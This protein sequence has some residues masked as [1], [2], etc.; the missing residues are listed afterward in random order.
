MRGR[1]GPLEL[2]VCSDYGIPQYP[3]HTPLQQSYPSP[4]VE[5]PPGIKSRS[6]QA[7]QR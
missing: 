5:T 2:E 7:T 3:L 6:L 4:V 1:A